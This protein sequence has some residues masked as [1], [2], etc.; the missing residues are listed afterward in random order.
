[1]KS[2]I[3]RVLRKVR[4]EILDIFEAPTRDKLLPPRRLRVFV[5]N[6][7][8]FT[9][10]GLENMK[11]LVSLANLQPDEKILDVGCGCGRLAVPLT[12]YMNEKGAY[13]G[14]DISK[15]CIDWCVSH[16]SLKFPNFNFQFVNIRNKHYNPKGR[17]KASEF[18]FPYN[19]E[20]FDVVS[21]TSVFT[22]LLPADLENYLSE[23]S[24]VLK[25]NGRCLITYFL[26]NQESQQL[27][28]SLP[29]D[30]IFKDTEQGYFTQNK[31]NPEA[32]VAY[33]EEAIR[34]LHEKYRVPIV[35]VYYGA[36]CGRIKAMSYQDVVI[37]YKRA[38]S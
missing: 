7:E 14:F 21:L 11:F 12:K 31:Q 20:T 38:H 15:K 5:G 33:Q 25:P 1:M 17:I 29:K 13:W 24:R 10:V 2:I 26:I 34:S 27:S 22:H 4:R 9:Q 28:N 35:E 36:W 3:G 19:D 30:K 32:A 8:D 37:A 6:E 23:I 16:I 18:K